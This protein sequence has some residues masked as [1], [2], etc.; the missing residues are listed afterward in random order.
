MENIRVKGK[1][2][3]VKGRRWEEEE[4]W[5]G[6]AKEKLMSEKEG[7]RGG[8]TGDW[9]PQARAEGEDGAEASPQRRLRKAGSGQRRGG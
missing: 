6:R 2:K 5:K 1:Y 9:E 3:R 8:Q 7:R 4:A